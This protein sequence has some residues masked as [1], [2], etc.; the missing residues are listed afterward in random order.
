MLT[1]FYTAFGTVCFTL[2]G[3]WLAVV[4]TRHSEWRRVAAHRRR[5][6]GVALHFSLPGLMSMLSL[7]NP[8]STTLWRASFA[9]VAASGAIVLLLVRGSLPT[10]VGRLAYLTAIALYV[11]IAVVAA[12]PSVVADIGL[13][14]R[15]L[16]VEAVLLIILV[17]FGVNV[18][19]LLLFDETPAAGHPRPGGNLGISTPTSRPDDAELRPDLPVHPGLRRESRRLLPRASTASAACCA[20]T[21]AGGQAGSTVGD[22]LQRAGHTLV[23]SP[24]D[25]AGWQ[26]AGQ[27]HPQP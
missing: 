4:Q 12:A 15:A 14:V 23:G 1:N 5:A 8:A 20:A 21:R 6:Y 18:A 24:A 11:L 25:W 19:W 10:A 22:P 2:L 27:R 3:L 17:Y 16:R 26:P 7:V 13:T 9:V